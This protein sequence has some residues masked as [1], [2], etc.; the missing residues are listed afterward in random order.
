MTRC[1]LQTNKQQTKSTLLNHACV[2]TDLY[3]FPSYVE[4]KRRYSEKCF[5]VF[6]FV[7]IVGI[8]Y[9]YILFQLGVKAKF[10]IYLVL[11]WSTKIIKTEWM[12]E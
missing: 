8:K 9:K 12:N 3:D 1:N 7:H 4:H 11:M 10:V 6:Y 5:S 2:V